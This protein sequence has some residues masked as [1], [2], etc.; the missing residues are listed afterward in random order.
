[1]NPQGVKTNEI[2]WND[3]KLISKEL[4]AQNHPHLKMPREMCVLMG[5]Y[6]EY[7]LADEWCHNKIQFICEY[8]D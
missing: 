6:N 1:M 4:W 7:R 2:K 5:F 3:G 8:K